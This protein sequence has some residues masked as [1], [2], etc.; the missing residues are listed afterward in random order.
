M[1]N[2]KWI[3]K[4]FNEISSTQ[5]Y[6][7]DRI[8]KEDLNYY[9]IWS[10]LQTDGIGTKNNKWVGEKGNLFFSFVVDLDEFDFIPLQSLS[11]YFSFLMFKVLKKYKSNL[12]IKWPNDIYLLENTPK[13]IA[14]VLVNIKQK[15]IIC[16]IGINTK[17]KVN[18][19]SEYEAGCL[20]LNIKNGKI[21]KDFLDLLLEKPCWESVFLEYKE[22]FE[23]YKKVFNIQAKLNNDATLKR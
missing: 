10:E 12:I 14:G 6:L 21:L 11:V 9:C 1:K 7:L 3:I 2:E 20:E 17:H 23:K 4:Y 5:K 16:G 8:E 13:K 19:K 18:L 22:I 15:K